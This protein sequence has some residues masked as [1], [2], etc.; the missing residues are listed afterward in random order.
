MNFILR[1]EEDVVC[2]G[3]R[4]LA[5]RRA[6]PH[7][8]CADPAH[9]EESPAAS[10]VAAA[11]LLRLTMVGHGKH[12]RWTRLVITREAITDTSTPTEFRTEL[13]VEAATLLRRPTSASVVAGGHMAKAGELVSEMGHTTTAGPTEDDGISTGLQ[14]VV[15]DG[16]RRA[17]G[18]RGGFVG[19]LSLAVEAAR[20]WRP[21][22]ETYAAPSADRPG[23]H[24]RT[25]GSYQSS[26][27]AP[28]TLAASEPVSAPARALARAPAA[29]RPAAT[30]P[31]RGSSRAP[32]PRAPPTTTL[33]RAEPAATKT[34]QS[35][36]L[37]AVRQSTIPPI[38]PSCHHHT[39]PAR[40]PAS[41]Q[42]HTSLAS[43]A[44]GGVGGGAVNLR[45]CRITKNGA[46]AV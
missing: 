13:P 38:V 16:S 33:R 25:G 21:G 11:P 24:A 41:K 17:P 40:V 8:D 4:P 31:R 3:K 42:V 34:A 36:G 14:P 29:A 43:P 5:G 44:D 22:P 26:S 39:H 12:R 37:A 7:K 19:R 30:A 6:S 20:H 1:P 23:A 9:T 15:S 27:A 2:I 10:L 18:R 45:Q 46:P 28:L 35:S 32:A